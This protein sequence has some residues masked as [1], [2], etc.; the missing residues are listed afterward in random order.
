MESQATW[1]SN[2]LLLLEAFNGAMQ[3]S[4]QLQ[5]HNQGNKA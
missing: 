1:E 3:S 5:L 2:L 4:G